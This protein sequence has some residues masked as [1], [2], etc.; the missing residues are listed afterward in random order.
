MA[1]TMETF[2]CMACGNEFRERVEEDEDKE[3]AC[4][5]CRSNSVRQIKGRKPAVKE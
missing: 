1:A 3:R 5:R 2:R 4:P